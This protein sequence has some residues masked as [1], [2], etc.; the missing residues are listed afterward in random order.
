MEC[1][2]K[3]NPV[4]YL[5]DNVYQKKKL[6]PFVR[7]NLIEG[8]IGAIIVFWIVKYIPFVPRVKAIVEWCLAAG[9]FIFNLRG[10]RHLSISENIIYAY[11][12][13]KNKGPWSFGSINH[14]KHKNIRFS[15]YGESPAIIIIKK[16]TR[17]VREFKETGE[18][19]F[20]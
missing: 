2:N 4:I 10:Y 18:I 19:H 9:V 11:K 16:I 17:I 5:T 1:D 14:E 15:G 6:G 20:K 3:G 13:H 7:R 8:I 12:E